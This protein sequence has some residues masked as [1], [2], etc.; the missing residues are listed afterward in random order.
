MNT[1]NNITDSDYTDAQIAHAVNNFYVK[2]MLERAEQALLHELFAQQRDIPKN[3]TGV[4]K[5]R[6]YNTLAQNTTALTEGVTPDGIPLTVTDVTATLSYYGD[7]VQL[8]DQ[9]IME[10]L[11]PLMTEA[12]EVLGQQMGESMDSVVRAAL[13][14]GVTNTVYAGTSNTAT[15]QV[16]TGDDATTADLD[17][18]ILGLKNNNAKKITSFVRPDPGSGTVPVREC[19]VGIFGVEAMANIKELTGFEH[20][21]TYQNMGSKLPSEIG[22][23]EDIR[24]LETTNDE[25]STGGGQYGQDVHKGLIFGANAFGVTKLS[26]MSAELIVKQLGSAGTKDPLNQRATMG[27]KTSRVAEVL[28]PSWIYSYE[29]SLTGE[30]T[31][32]SPSVSPSSSASASS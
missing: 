13:Y 31:S 8:S 20:V 3:N 27:W 29:F 4:I 28:N 30:T 1:V 2:T 17:T 19:Y 23:Y 18:I 22:R 16:A 26:G 15:N 5:F 12:A 10:T 14:A 24:F 25:V 11:D 9:L 7:Y 21:E 6:R 32:P